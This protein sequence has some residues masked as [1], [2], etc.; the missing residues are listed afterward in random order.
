MPRDFSSSKKPAGDLPKKKKPEHPE[1]K[2]ENSDSEI[3]FIAGVLDDHAKKFHKKENFVK[4]IVIPADIKQEME[5]MEKE[6]EEM[7]DRMFALESHK[8]LVQ[9]KMEDLTGLYDHHVHFDD[10]NNHADFFKKN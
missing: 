10:D 4:R 1:H 3:S 9:A 2:E 6:Y 7:R 5:A 8:N